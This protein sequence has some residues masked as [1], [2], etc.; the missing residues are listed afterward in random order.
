MRNRRRRGEDRHL[1]R[2]GHDAAALRGHGSSPH[3]GPVPLRS[4]SAWGPSRSLEPR[5]YARLEGGFRGGMCAGVSAA[6][7]G[8]PPIV[9]TTASNLCASH[10]ARTGAPAADLSFVYAALASG[11]PA[12][13]RSFLR[14][15]L[16][17]RTQDQQHPDAQQRVPLTCGGAA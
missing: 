16:T 17:P 3:L 13:K 8:Q 1:R 10:H 15:N 5:L 4:S 2:P 14:K 6:Q 12:V 7:D 11:E 9:P